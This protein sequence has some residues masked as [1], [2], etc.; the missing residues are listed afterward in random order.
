MMKK[1]SL[2][3]PDQGGGSGDGDGCE[4]YF[5]D[6]NGEILIAMIRGKPRDR[7]RPS[8]GG[9]RR[10]F[11]L[12]IQDR[13]RVGTVRFETS[14]EAHCLAVESLYLLRLFRFFFIFHSYTGL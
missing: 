3:T 2:D 4:P 1:R 10:I 13:G 11:A 5:A 14:R 8:R 9:G 7:G 6:D 12:V